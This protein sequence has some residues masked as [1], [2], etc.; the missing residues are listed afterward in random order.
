MATMFDIGDKLRLTGTF[1]VSAV[2]TDPTA[3]VLQ[4]KDPTGNVTTYTYALA[5]I[6]KS[7]TGV[8]YRDVSID[9]SGV[10]YYRWSGTGAVETAEEGR[11]QVR[12]PAIA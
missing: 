4:V 1:T 12:V 2:N 7:A 11:I 8:Y 10:W 5:E 3:V 9:E 6:V